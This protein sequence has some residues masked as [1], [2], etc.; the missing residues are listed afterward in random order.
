MLGSSDILTNARPMPPDFPT[1][2]PTPTFKAFDTAYQGA[3]HRPAC[4]CQVTPTRS[5][6]DA[7]AIETPAN[8]LGTPGYVAMGE[9]VHRWR[10]STDALCR[11]APVGTTIEEQIRGARGLRRATSTP[12]E[13]VT[14]APISSLAEERLERLPMRVVTIVIACVLFLVLLAIS[15]FLKPT[16]E[17]DEKQLTLLLAVCCMLEEEFPKRFSRLNI[18][19]AT[20]LAVV[21]GCIY[22][23]SGLNDLTEIAL[24]EKL[25]LVF[26]QC[27]FWAVSTVYGSVV[28]YHSAN[29]APILGVMVYV[30]LSTPRP[31]PP[32][33]P[34]L[35]GCRLHDGNQAC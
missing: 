3:T 23:D 19:M 35:P 18:A 32:A 28:S 15:I 2:E 11:H 33:A 4:D 25:A 21:A 10:C 12:A 6:S 14:E 16:V 22:F 8:Y 27:A 13:F 1:C 5:A 31:P 34:P 30:R 20:G 17:I 24:G 7:L 26:W 9:P 29:W